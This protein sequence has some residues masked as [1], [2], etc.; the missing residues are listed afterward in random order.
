[1]NKIVSFSGG[2]DSTAMLLRMIE[3]K[4]P[5]DEIVFADTGLEYPEMNKYIKK[6]ER[7]IGR[8]I[9]V[10][11]GES[12]DKWFYGKWS[13]G[14]HKGKMRGFPKVCGIDWCTRELKVK[15]LDKIKGIHYLGIAL[16]EKHRVQKDK[17]KRYPLIEWEWTEQKCIQYLKEK[18]M[19]NPLYFKF[20]RLGCW[21]CPKQ[22]Q[23]ALR[24]LFEDYPKLWEKLKVY[25]KSSMFR[26]GFKL[27]EFE[28]KWK[29]QSKLFVEDRGEEHGK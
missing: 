26:P 6:V 27:K 5:F 17:N 25:E 24:I 14:K 29:N 12:W 13:R 10:V 21:C 19:L 23:E 2:K 1:M 11:K 16:D 4:M 7:F 28:D 15:P 3:L 8:K 20:K 9:K 18:N 22:S